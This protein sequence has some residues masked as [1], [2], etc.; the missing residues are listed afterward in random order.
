MSGQ[1]KDAYEALLAERNRLAREC[2]D[3]RD[4]RDEMAR[5][6]AAIKDHVEIIDDDRRRL[7]DELEKATGR[8]WTAEEARRWFG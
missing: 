5:E 1:Q 8:D 4:Q 7:C 3:L 2:A 6:V